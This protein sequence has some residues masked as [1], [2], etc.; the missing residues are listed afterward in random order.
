MMCWFVS[1][2]SNFKPFRVMVLYA[3]TAVHPDELS[4]SVGDCIDVLS[5]VLSC[6]LVVYA[7]MQT[8]PWKIWDELSAPSTYINVLVSN[9]L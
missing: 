5:E 8:I 7:C 4:L 9:F 6:C 2:G 1:S 3:Y